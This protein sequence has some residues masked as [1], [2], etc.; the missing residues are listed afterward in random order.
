LDVTLGRVLDIDK[1]DRVAYHESAH[2]ILYSVFQHR[3]TFVE[4]GE[5]TG[6]CGVV[7]PC[8]E[9]SNHDCNSAR[10]E[11]Q[12]HLER[13][14]SLFA[15]KC[16]MDRLYG[17]KYKDDTNWRASRDY[18]QACES[19]LQLNDGDSLGAELLMAWAERRTDK[20]IEERWPDVQKLAYALRENHRLTGN[21]VSEILA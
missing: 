16:A 7:Q 6:G 5:H 15:G 2:A 14:L 11:F 13:I 4:I 21:E 9:S 10:I 17:Y 8:R 3:V 1:I 19:A 12:V 18:K 20:L